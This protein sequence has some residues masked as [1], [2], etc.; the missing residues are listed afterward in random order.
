[1]PQLDVS[2]ALINNG[3]VERVAALSTEHDYSQWILLMEEKYDE[4]RLVKHAGMGWQD[5]P[6]GLRPEKPYEDAIWNDEGG[7]WDNPDP[8]SDGN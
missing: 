6:D 7:Y 3:V 4:V 8:D 2:A 5:T 1:M